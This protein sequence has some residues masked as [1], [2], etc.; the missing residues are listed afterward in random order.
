MPFGVYKPE[1][2][3]DKPIEKVLIKEAEMPLKPIQ[4]PKRISTPKIEKPIRRTQI[5]R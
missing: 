4:K 1:N 3:D 2:T 5:S